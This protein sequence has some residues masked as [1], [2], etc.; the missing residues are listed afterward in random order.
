MLEA[1]KEGLIT[2]AV[3]VAATLMMVTPFTRALL[4]R[5]P[6]QLA[7]VCS[8]LAFLVG[9]YR[10]LRLLEIRRFRHAARALPRSE[11]PI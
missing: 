5:S 6:L 1:A 9:C 7:L 8:A 11:G 4:E 2:L 3:A 10:G